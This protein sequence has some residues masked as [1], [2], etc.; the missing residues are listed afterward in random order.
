MQGYIC[1]M[2]DIDKNKELTKEYGV[3]AIPTM[4]MLDSDGKNL[5]KVQ[6]RDPQGFIDD[7]KKLTTGK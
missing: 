2:I 4:F 5:G 7:I 3:R 6:K 1:V